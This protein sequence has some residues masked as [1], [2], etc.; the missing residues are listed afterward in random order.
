[1]ISF[2]VRRLVA[3]VPL[4]A[5][6]SMLAF[7][8]ILLLPGDPALMMLGDEAANANNRQAYYALRKELGL[9]EPI[10]VQYLRWVNR[11]LQGDLGTSIRNKLPIGATIADHIF[12]TAELAVLAMVCALAIAIPSGIISALKPNSPAD[13][14]GTVVALS[15]VA[16]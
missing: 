16:V 11:A 4:L 5:I 8:L 3:L 14:V 6:V 2:V 15:G 13:V 12:P 10:P 9:D 7:S 1:M